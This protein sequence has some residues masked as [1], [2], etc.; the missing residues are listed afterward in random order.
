MSILRII[1]KWVSLSLVSIIALLYL[2]KT[3]YI[4]KAVRVVYLNGET[5]ASIDDYVYFENS[6]IK[7]RDASV[8]PKH[9]DYNSLYMPEKLTLLHEDSR[10]I[11]YLV[12]KNDS[13]LH[14]SYFDGY[15]E[16]SK[17]NSFSM[18]KSYVCALL[19]KA[20]MDGH[21]ESLDQPV[22]D[23]F[24]EYKTGL[25]STVTVGDLASMA[26]GSSWVESY[27]SPF[28]ITTRAYYGEELEK[29]IFSLNTVKTPGRA[30]EYSSGDTQ[31]LAM[32]IEKAT[33]EKLYN[34]LSKSLWIPL[35]SE[36]DALWQVDSQKNDMVK[37]YCCIAS[38]AKD[39]ARLGRLYKDYG[40]WN[41]KKILDSTYV[42]KSINPRFEKSP[43]YGYG[44]WLNKINDK[45]FFMME[46]HLGQCVIVEPTDNL[47]IVR[48]GH[49]KY[50]FGNNP[51]NGDVTTYIEETYKMLGIDL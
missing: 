50:F 1:F 4:L 18:A 44:F 27:Y 38:N 14:E 21:I 2:T 24:E 26:S 47:I 3:D 34:Y 32:I 16:N 36:N 5:T 20:I 11:A 46:G 37:A 43:Q 42:V 13:L 25:A 39:F 22:G 6:T 7:N 51:Y 48:L 19:G 23:F 17:T 31:L 35:E 41:G 30:F 12:I 33:G 29:A 49:E 15:D 28:T 8:W 9:K 10:S 45:S 40:K